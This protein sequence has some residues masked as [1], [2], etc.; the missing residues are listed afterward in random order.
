MGGDGG[1]GGGGVTGEM[2]PFFCNLALGTWTSY[3]R[4]TNYVKNLYNVHG[5]VSPKT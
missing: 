1:G 3:V 2:G 5:T 4:K